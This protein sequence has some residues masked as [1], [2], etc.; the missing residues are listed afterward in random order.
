MCLHAGS[1]YLKDKVK[2]NCRMYERKYM[3]AV[4]GIAD[5]K[6]AAPCD[7]VSVSVLQHHFKQAELYLILKT[8]SVILDKKF[9][10]S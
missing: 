2:N 7:P 5:W 4:K 8:V 6:P 1:S 3:I 10:K 9:C